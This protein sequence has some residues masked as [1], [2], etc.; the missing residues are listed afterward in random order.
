MFCLIPAPPS[1]GR[2]TKYTALPKISNKSGR[3]S[4]SPTGRPA[5]ISSN[6]EFNYNDLYDEDDDC[7]ILIG[8]RLPDGTKK[9]KTFSSNTKLKTILKFGLDETEV[10]KSYTDL[11]MF[12]LLQLP[13]NVIDNLE[14]TINEANIQNR[15]MLFI[16]DKQHC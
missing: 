8:L 15:S 9:Q 10:V 3:D 7:N 6:Y 13:N 4:Y 11:S 16:I 12:T 5:S 14:Q 1:S 2:L